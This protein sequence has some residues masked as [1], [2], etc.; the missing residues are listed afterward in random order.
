MRK[1]FDSVVHDF[2]K[3]N[4]ARRFKDRRLL[5]L[6]A[7]IVDGYSTTPGRGIP[8]GNLTSQYFAN[9]YLAGMDHLVREELRIPGYLRYMDDFVLW[10]D[11]R[12]VLVAAEGRVR[13]YCLSALG[14]V[15]K[16]PCLNRTVRGVTM[17]GY[18]VFPDHVR[19]ARRS[20]GRFVRR[21][22]A[23]WG[24]LMT[25]EWSQETFAAHVL[26]LVAY[27]DHARSAGFRRAVMTRIGC[28]P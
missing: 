22:R 26:P 16:P 23:Y 13:D 28:S 25:G 27:V 14:L 11:D 17:L 4:L 12:Q 3:R 7:R 10:H 5:A 15:L 18:R 2:L 9:D 24:D 8:I 21:L 6:F 1:Y 20:R 19:L